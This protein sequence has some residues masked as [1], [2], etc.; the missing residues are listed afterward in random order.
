M[1]DKAAAFFRTLQQEI[2]GGL[3]RLDGVGQ[4]VEDSWERSGGGGGFSRVLSEGAVFE[5]AG[6]NWSDVHGHLPADMEGSSEPEPFRATGV[7]LVLHPRSPMIPTVHANFRMIRRADQ[8]WFG[9]GADLTP[10]FAHVEDAVHFHSVLQAACARHDPAW[11]PRFKA[12]CDEYFFL[13]HRGETR[14]VGGVFYDYLGMASADLSPAVLAHS[15]R[16]LEDAVDLERGFAFTQDIG[17]HFLDAYLPIVE[18]HVDTP[19]NEEDRKFQLLR[20]G[21]Y[22]EFNLIYDRGTSFGLR[23]GGRTESILMSLPP[24]VRWE[25][26][27]VPKEGSRQAELLDFLRPQDWLKLA[28]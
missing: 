19:Y 1:L 28:S 23:T 20:R 22:V 6:V 11:Y 17:S 5:R 25:Y 14:G 27:H 4:F 15:P 12:W 18:R 13:P 24:I 8:E 21:R 2:C 9:G 3:E 16:A 7:S 26:D 10:Y